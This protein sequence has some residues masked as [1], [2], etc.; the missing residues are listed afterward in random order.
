MRS[1]YYKTVSFQNISWREESAPS[2]RIPITQ[3]E[4]SEISALQRTVAAL[5]DEVSQLSDQ[6][7]ARCVSRT[8]QEQYVRVI[9]SSRARRPERQEESSYCSVGAILRLPDR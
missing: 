5:A 3:S 9:Q 2:V 7:R 1:E 4:N 8:Q 6:G